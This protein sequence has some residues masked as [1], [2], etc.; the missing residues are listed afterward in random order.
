MLLYYVADIVSPFK[1]QDEKSE[2]NVCQPL[3]GQHIGIFKHCLHL[4]IKQLF[5]ASTMCKVLDHMLHSYYRL[6]PFTTITGV[7]FKMMKNTGQGFNSSPTI[8]ELCDSGFVT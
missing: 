8:Y 4:F 5:A 7:L 6:F 3:Q 2:V 1:G